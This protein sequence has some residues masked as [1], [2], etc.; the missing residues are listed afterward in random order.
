MNMQTLRAEVANDPLARGYTGMDDAAVAASLNAEDRPAVKPVSNKRYLVWLAGERRK[1]LADAAASHASA[2]VQ[3]LAQM[4]L[5]MISRPDV[6]YERGDHKAMLDGLV[7][8]G[9][10]GADDS[11]A[12]DDQADA[13][14]SRAAELGLPVV[15]AGDVTMARRV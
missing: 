10:L 15:R 6:D 1:K 7:A 13:D 12:L 4:A 14:I 2:A 5:D 11:E 9:V 3:G 8:G